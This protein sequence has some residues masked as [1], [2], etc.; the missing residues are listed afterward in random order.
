MCV[1]VC[2]FMSIIGIDLLRHHNLII[3]TCKRRLVYGDTNLPVCVT[4]FFG[5]RLSPV[6]VRHTIDPYYQ[7]ILGNYPEAYQIQPKLPYVTCNVTLY[8]MT[9]GTS[10][11]SKA[12][13]IAVGQLWLDKNEFSHIMDLWIIRLSSSPRAPPLKMFHRK[14]SNDWHPTGECWRINMKPFLFFI[15][16][17][18]FTTWR[19]PWKV[20]LFFFKPG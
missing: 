17:L 10:L 18:T 5:W 7:H 13:R 19:L 3:D 2:I 6:T 8:I 9:T 1:A 20:R 12:L 15:R 16:Y 4:G 11:F 14:E